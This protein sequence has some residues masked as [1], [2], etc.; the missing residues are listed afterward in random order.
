MIALSH[1]VLDNYFGTGIR[2]EGQKYFLACIY[3]SPSEDHD[4]FD[5]FCTKFNLLLSNKIHEFLYVQMSQEIS[6]LVAQ[7]GGKMILLPQRIYKSS[8]SDYQQDISK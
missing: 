4:E 7:D 3:R 1:S 5:N 8:L 6:M 2:S